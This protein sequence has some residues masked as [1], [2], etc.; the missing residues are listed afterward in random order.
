MFLQRDRDP[1]T[2]PITHDGQEILKHGKQ[3]I[4]SSHRQRQFHKRDAHAPQPARNR[5]R[6]PTQ[7]LNCQRR[8]VSAGRVVGHRAQ[9]ED[10]D[11]EATE[12]A[13]AVVGL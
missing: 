11:A 9:G 13:E 7:H 1:R 4:P 8:G 6:I 5:L 3:M 12:A 10:D 2:N